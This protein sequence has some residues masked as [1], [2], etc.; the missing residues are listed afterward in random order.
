MVRGSR[1]P[2]SVQLQQAQQPMQRQHLG[3][4]LLD[5]A[6]AAA[7]PARPDPRSSRGARRRRSARRRRR[8]GAGP[9]ARS[10]AASR[11]AWRLAGRGARPAS[12]G[13]RPARRAL[14]AAPAA[15]APP[16]AS[17]GPPSARAARAGATPPSPGRAA[18][19]SRGSEPPAPP[20]PPP[21]RAPSQSPC[22]RGTR[23]QT[24]SAVARGRIVVMRRSSVFGAMPRDVVASPGR[25]ICSPPNIRLVADGT[26]GRIRRAA[27]FPSHATTSRASGPRRAPANACG[28]GAA[29]DWSRAPRSARTD[30]R[31]PHTGQSARRGTGSWVTSIVRR[32]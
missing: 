17:R 16:P 8:R 12:R 18:A 9:R 6:P 7:R 13:C 1:R 23:R 21:I 19:P 3:R 14:P 31:S 30:Y 20:G 15:R 32:S 27:A 28:A 11:T 2:P 26:A 24:G 22:R 25:F 4:R 10:A 29:R 5:P